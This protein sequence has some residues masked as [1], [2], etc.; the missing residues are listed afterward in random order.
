MPAL[1]SLL[2][3]NRELILKGVAVTVLAFAAWWYFIHNPKTIKALE[4][5]VMETQRQVELRDNAINLLGTISREK[6][7]ITNA[8]NDNLRKIRTGNKPSVRGVFVHDGMLA[9][10]YTDGATH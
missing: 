2:W 9:D 7:K 3:S 8:E 6:E 10:L 5:K 1:L 4:V